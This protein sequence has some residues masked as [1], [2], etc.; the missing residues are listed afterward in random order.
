[1]FGDIGHRGH[2]RTALGGRVMVELSTVGTLVT[3]SLFRSQTRRCCPAVSI[4]DGYGMYEP[5][6]LEFELRSFAGDAWQ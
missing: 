6:G 4:H 5:Y 1:M 3:V 2:T